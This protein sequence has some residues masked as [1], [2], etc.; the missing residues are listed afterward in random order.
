MAESVTIYNPSYGSGG[1]VV[2]FSMLAEALIN[3]GTYDVII[4]DYNGGYTSNYLDS[5]KLQYGFIEYSDCISIPKDTNFVINSLCGKLIGKTIFLS[6]K[7]KV[8]F[9]TTFIFDFYKYIPLYNFFYKRTPRWKRFFISLLQPKMYRKMQIFL[10]KID[11]SKGVVYMDNE[12]KAATEEIF[13][14]KLTGSV[15]PIFTSNPICERDWSKSNPE[16]P[17]NI[18][19]LGRLGDFKYS[20]VCSIAKSIAQSRVPGNFIFHIIGDGPEYEYC[21][22]YISKLGCVNARFYGHVDQEE[23]DVI[24]ANN[25]DILIGHG[26]SILHGARL[27]IPCILIDGMYQVFEPEQLKCGWLHDQKDKNVG[28]ISYRSKEFQGVTLCSILNELD[29]LS[30]TSLGE[31][32]FIYWSENHSAS[33]VVAEYADYLGGNTFTYQDFLSSDVGE[34]NTLL[35]KVRDMLKPAFYRYLKVE[36]PMDR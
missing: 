6:P 16:E 28:K 36:K 22:N 9:F 23:L 26:L 14:V 27:K 18:F 7:T 20:T 30:F 3:K 29:K 5:K 33:S 24:L 4:I 35:I 25:A 15:I 17:V 2:L 31:K 34:K 32:S 1:T 19:W 21:R 10:A 12:T 13:K 11:E 8:N